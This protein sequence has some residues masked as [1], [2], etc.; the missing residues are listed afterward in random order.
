[1]LK[2]SSC[3]SLD[4]GRI[5]HD[6]RRHSERHDFGSTVTGRRT[7]IRVYSFFMVSNLCDSV[8]LSGVNRSS[9]IAMQV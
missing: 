9:L 2:N 3:C 4:L 1:M 5:L 6:K 8:D 7:Q